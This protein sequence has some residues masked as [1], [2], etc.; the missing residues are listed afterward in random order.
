MPCTL[1]KN[2]DQRENN[3]LPSLHGVR[4]SVQCCS[5]I[6]KR[7]WSERWCVVTVSLPH[8]LVQHLHIHKEKSATDNGRPV[9]FRGT[10]VNNCFS[11][12][13]DTPSPF[14]TGAIGKSTEMQSAT[15]INT[16]LAGL[17]K[18]VMLRYMCLS[19]EGLK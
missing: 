3:Y 8:K 9:R 5:A 2:V 11:W 16:T 14:G 18:F 6:Y 4:L 13:T 17:S 1:L 19:Q 15:H 7:D 10:I 12:K